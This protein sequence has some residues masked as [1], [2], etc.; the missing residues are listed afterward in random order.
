VIIVKARRDSITHKFGVQFCGNQSRQLKNTQTMGFDTRQLH[1]GFGLETVGTGL[2]RPTRSAVA[3]RFTCTPV[4]SIATL[5]T[6]KPVSSCCA[7]H[8]NWRARAGECIAI[9][10]NPAS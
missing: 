2:S 9:A 7:R 3:S 10:G 4:Q 6:R 5:S 1:P 8:C